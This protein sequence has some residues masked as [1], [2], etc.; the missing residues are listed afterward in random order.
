MRRNEL[1]LA[2]AFMNIFCSWKKEKKTFFLFSNS[3][4]IHF[5]LNVCKFSKTNDTYSKLLWKK[6]FCYFFSL[7]SIRN[8]K[9]TFISLL[10]FFFCLYQHISAN[11][12]G[13]K[14]FFF[15]SFLF[16]LV[17]NLGK[18]FFF[19]QFFWELRRRSFVCFF[20]CFLVVDWLEV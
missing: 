19:L 10:V 16:F 7:I 20:I 9:S 5:W 18:S 14:I 17:C 3:L 8:W 12:C 6:F 1:C 2:F 4:I 15:F 13:K 11:F